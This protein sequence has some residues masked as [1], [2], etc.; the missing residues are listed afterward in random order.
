MWGN[1]TWQRPILARCATIFSL[2]SERI[3]P[4]PPIYFGRS[5]QSCDPRLAP[6]EAGATAR[7]SPQFPSAF[8]AEPA[9]L[10]PR[11]RVSWRI[12]ENSNTFGDG[13]T[14]QWR[15]TCT[16]RFAGQHFQVPPTPCGLA[17]ALTH[18]G[19]ESSHVF[20]LSLP[21]HIALATQRARALVVVASEYSNREANQENE[22]DGDGT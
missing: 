22:A 2:I 7:G 18:S 8:V 19:L 14:P 15:P 6:C 3:A 11:Q 10:S 9:C 16:S 12:G 4:V 1:A 13:A 17:L 21:A 5:C 20:M